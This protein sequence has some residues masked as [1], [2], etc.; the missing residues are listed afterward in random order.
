MMNRI[1]YDAAMSRKK[2]RLEALAASRERDLGSETDSE[3]ENQTKVRV[4]RLIDRLVG[5][6]VE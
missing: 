6:L 4:Y 1:C 5:W 2:T 3:E